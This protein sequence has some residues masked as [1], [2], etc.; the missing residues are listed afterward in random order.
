MAS[1]YLLVIDG[2]QGESLDDKRPNSIEVES[3]TWG[4]Q[5]DGSAAAGTGAG[6][7]RVEFKD[8]KFTSYVSRAS[9]ELAKVC[10]SGKHIKKAQ[11]FVRKQGQQQQEYYVITLE[12][13]IVSA[14]DS[15]GISENQSGVPLDVFT[16][17]FST[18]RFDYRL[19][20]ADGTLGPAISMGWSVK[21]N[22]SL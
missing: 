4:H 5:N 11:L 17:N 13:F 9:P 12:D 7:G 20:K 15:G 21:E 8:I 2:I 10:A 18:I 19:Q 6:S 1:D 3:F 22:K 14:F 16:L